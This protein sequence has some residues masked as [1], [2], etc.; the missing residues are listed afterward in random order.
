MTISKTT[1]NSP[2]IVAPNT[3]IKPP[4]TNVEDSDIEPSKQ[5]QKPSQKV[6]DLLEG[7]GQWSMNT[8]A[9]T[10]APGI[11]KP[12]N[13]WTAELI[14]YEDEYV[15]LAEVSNSEALEPRNC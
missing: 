7:R 11:Q 9:M 1:N 15:F 5:I 4:A 6:A 12:S 3:D 10:L 2:N 13:D 8:K 14:K